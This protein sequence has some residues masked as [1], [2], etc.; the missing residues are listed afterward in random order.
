MFFRASNLKDLSR[1]LK[2]RAAGM[3]GD[4]G[5]DL[6]DAA[7]KLADAFNGLMV[8][9]SPTEDKV[10]LLFPIYTNKNKICT[11]INVFILHLI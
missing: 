6:L 2:M 8:A 10:A 7:K 11:V 5:N 4:D 1:H 9:I 3:K